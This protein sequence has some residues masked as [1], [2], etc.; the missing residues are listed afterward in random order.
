MVNP[1]LEHPA[2]DFEELARVL[3][4]EQAPQR[5]HLAELTID[6]EILQAISERFLGE[7]WTPRGVGPDEHYYKQMVNIYFRLGYDYVPTWAVWKNHPT[8][9]SRVAQ[10]TAQLPHRRGERV[11]VE[12]GRGLI[13]SWQ[14]FEQFPWDDVAADSA[15]WE[16]IAKHLPRGMKMAVIGICFEHVME[17]LL[18]YEGLFLLLHDD[19]EL[20]GQVF[21]RWG[22]KVYD[23]YEAVVGLD[24]VGAIFHAD[25]LGYKTSTLLSPAA[26]REHVFPWFKRYA[27]LAHAH[28]KMYWYHCCGNIYSSG[29]IQ[30]LIDD[31]G[32][33]AL[34]SFQ[35]VILPVADFQRQ[36][37]DRVAAL[38]GPDVDKLAR[39]DAIGVRALTRE[40]LERCMPAGRFA[41]GSGNSVTNYIPVENYCIM[42]EEARCWSP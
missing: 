11:W 8:P 9:L 29:V 34:H 16:L 19:P 15:A 28:G 26:L 30:D 18:G 36:Y 14:E 24:Q 17:R 32:T 20:A 35:D 39:L 42:L 23:F 27:E 1:L 4:G 33:D 22:Q 40:I 6:Q 38:G 31:V 25:D 21:A 10:D 5:V 41:L 37:G 12:E 13:T 7:P 3:R 2:P